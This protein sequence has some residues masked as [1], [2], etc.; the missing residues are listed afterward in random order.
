MILI[1]YLDGHVSKRAKT[2][3]DKITSWA[4]IR[5]QLSEQQQ[6]AFIEQHTLKM[7]LMQKEYDIKIKM[8][9]EK[10]QIELQNLKLT[11]EILLLQIEKEKRILKLPNYQ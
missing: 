5:T 7:N 4:T 8:M 3:Q 11:N 9:E 10:Y 1:F 6:S 2:Y